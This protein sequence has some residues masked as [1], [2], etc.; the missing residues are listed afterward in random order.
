MDIAAP[1][2]LLGGHSPAQFMRRHWQH[3]P[4]LVR[5]AV[6]VLDA[7]TREE[8]LAWATRNDVRSR[9]VRQSGERWRLQHG[10]IEAEELT[11]LRGKWSL[12]VQDADLLHD[13]LHRLLQRFRFV[14]DARLDDAMVSI[15]SDGG[16]V[17]PHVDSYDV[18]LVQAQGRRRWRWGRQAALELRA[19]APLKILREFHPHEK[20]V[21]DPG[22]MLYLP[23]S[24]AHE[25][26]AV[27]PC[28]TVS[29]GFRAP[30]RNELAGELAARIAQ[31]GADE[32][33]ALYADRRMEATLTPARIPDALAGFAGAAVADAL[34]SR[35]AV[36]RALGEWLSEPKEHVWFEAQAVPRLPC[37]VTVDRR[38]RMLYDATHV[39]ANGES[40]RA[41]GADARL[42]RRL[43]DQRELSRAE[44]AAASAQARA[45][46]AEWL[47]A[48]WLHAT[49][50]ART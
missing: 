23:P 18:F 38:T 3:R 36:G 17:G 21:L 41:A 22:D 50:G 35:G 19:D 16:G 48:G 34:R 32:L 31:A 8:V 45:L 5:G 37:A 24:H 20:A 12:L 9:L 43:A 28:M 27:G 46:I 42:M 11:R 14:P 25:G 6:P 7:P 33:G 44:V 1:A 26:V 29:I 4:L 30:A 49:A 39:F 47:A 2:S 10:P 40:W 13:G 15:A